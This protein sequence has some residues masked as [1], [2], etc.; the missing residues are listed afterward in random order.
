MSGKVQKQLRKLAKK[1]LEEIKNRMPQDQQQKQINVIATLENFI[2]LVMLLTG[3]KPT[4]L[5][6]TDV[7]YNMYVQAVL[8][9]AEAFGLKPGFKEDEPTFIGIKLIKKSPIIVPTS[10]TP[11]E[12]VN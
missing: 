8:E 12:P 4:S 2:Q 5:T 6:L 9:N 10:T 11:I 1:E 7:M 3:E